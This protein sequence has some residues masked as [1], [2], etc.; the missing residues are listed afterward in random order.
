MTIKD[1]C[2]GLNGDT[3]VYVHVWYGGDGS[4]MLL[5]F[6][7]KDVPNYIKNYAVQFWSSGKKGVSI[8]ISKEVIYG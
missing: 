2:N 3:M 8:F 6:L 7:A 1:L 4:D 5:K